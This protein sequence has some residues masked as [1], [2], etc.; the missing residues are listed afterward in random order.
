[1][2]SQLQTLI[3]KFAIIGVFLAIAGASPTANSRTCP[4]TCE[5][6][7]TGQETADQFYDLIVAFS[8]CAGDHND[9]VQNGLKAAAQAKKIFEIQQSNIT[10][11]AKKFQANNNI[12]ALNSTTTFT[13]NK[14]MEISS[15]IEDIQRKFDC[16]LEV[17]PSIEKQAAALLEAASKRQDSAFISDVSSARGQA[18]KNISDSMYH[19]PDKIIYYEDKR[20]VEV[21]RQ[22]SNDFKYVETM[23]P[24]RSF[25][26]KSQEVLKPLI[27]HV[28]EVQSYSDSVS[29]SSVETSEDLSKSVKKRVEYP[30]SYIYSSKTT[31]LQMEKQKQ[32][33]APP[34]PSF[35]KDSTGVPGGAK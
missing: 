6:P 11:S 22:D 15:S 33:T 25:N 35:Q 26:K 7:I 10:N 21:H 9:L 29:G 1:M 28:F 19:F 17:A 3:R 32:E 27:D 20:G 2:K 12:A 34:V 30:D 4:F 16:L 8:S 18:I 14:L 13:G 31:D 24:L 23:E 5:R